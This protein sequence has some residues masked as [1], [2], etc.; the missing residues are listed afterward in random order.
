MKIGSIL[1]V[2]YSDGIEKVKVLAKNVIC[3][4]FE[5]LT[6]KD[7]SVCEFSPPDISKIKI[8]DVWLDYEIE[9]DF[10][11]LQNDLDAINQVLAERILKILLPKIKTGTREDG[12]GLF[13]DCNINFRYL[14]NYGGVFVQ[15]LVLEV[16]KSEYIEIE[17]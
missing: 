5:N 9:N 13:L 11:I 3:K 4:N 15:N 16:L 7:I 8:K 2:K 10:Q 17:P 1:N 14:C 6:D 12:Y